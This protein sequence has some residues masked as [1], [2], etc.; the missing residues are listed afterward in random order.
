MFTSH[1]FR[2][3]VSMK[4]CDLWRFEEE[5]QRRPDQAPEVTVEMWLALACT[6]TLTFGLTVEKQILWIH[7]FC[8]NALKH[9]PWIA[10]AQRSQYCVTIPTFTL[11]WYVYINT[12]NVWVL[13]KTLLSF[14]QIRCLFSQST[15]KMNEYGMMQKWT[16]FTGY[17]HQKTKAMSKTAYELYSR[18]RW[19]CKVRD[20]NCWSR[21]NLSPA[22]GELQLIFFSLSLESNSCNEDSGS[23]IN[24]QNQQLLESQDADPTEL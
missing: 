5:V 7:Y 23:G 21:S 6:S 3:N 19:L 14:T 20:E 9:R 15:T 24:Q 4:L 12:W 10:K 17:F 16:K 1:F 8:I 11:F 18:Y 2:K 13:T 22:A